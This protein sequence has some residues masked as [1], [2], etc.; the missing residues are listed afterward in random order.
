MDAQPALIKRAVDI[1]RRIKILEDSARQLEF[2]ID[3]LNRSKAQ[4]KQLLELL[5]IEERKLKSG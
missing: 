1:G 5:W 2:E 3:Q 4:V